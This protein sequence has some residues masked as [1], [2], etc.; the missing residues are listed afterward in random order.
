MFM[1]AAG[2]TGTTKKLQ[3][4]LNTQKSP[5]LNQATQKILTKF[6]GI[7][8]VKPK[9]IHESSRSLEI[10]ST[11]LGIT[12]G[13]VWLG[14][15]YTLNFRDFLFHRKNFNAVSRYQVAGNCFQNTLD[16]QQSEILTNFLKIACLIPLRKQYICLE[17]S[18]DCK[19]CLGLKVEAT[20]ELGH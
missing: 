18:S 13:N 8:N 10:R 4:V 6:P 2:Y 7:E 5:Y 9:K 20:V 3:F 19:Y 15:L 16:T 17:I 12:C 11:P 1:L 14:L